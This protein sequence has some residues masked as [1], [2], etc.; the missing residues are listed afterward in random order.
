MHGEKL[1]MAGQTSAFR[2]ACGALLLMLAGCATPPHEVVPPSTGDASWRAAIPPAYARYQLALGE[3]S[4]G[5]TPFPR[6]TPVN[7]QGL[8]A[9]RPP[10]PGVEALLLFH[11]QRASGRVRERE[12]EEAGGT[13][14]SLSH[15]G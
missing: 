7:P 15:T 9:R 5:G 13:D 3:V 10:P 14:H 2:H 4:G 6:V 1:S 11:S 12:G 8:P